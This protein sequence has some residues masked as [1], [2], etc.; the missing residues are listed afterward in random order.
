M[1]YLRRNLI[2]PIVS[3]IAT[4]SVVTWTALIT[5]HANH[6]LVVTLASQNGA[7]MAD[8]IMRFLAQFDASK[9]AA[10]EAKVS[11][12]EVAECIIAIFKKLIL[13]DN[14][15]KVAEIAAVTEI[16]KTDYS[17]PH[18]SN[19]DAA[20]AFDLERMMQIDERSLA[21]IAHILRQSLSTDQL[22]KLREN[23]VSVALTDGE[24]HPFEEDLINLFDEL[25]RRPQV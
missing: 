10:K 23:L 19:P 22:D 1:G 12:A 16:I 25:T 17:Q 20:G 5:T 3:I 15:I 13:A 24:L 11:E 14:A 6:V 8:D 21:S 18:S 7:D 2:G 4:G 9:A